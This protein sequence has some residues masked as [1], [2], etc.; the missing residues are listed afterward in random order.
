MPVGDISLSGAINQIKATIEGSPSKH[1]FFFMV[2]AGVSQ[3]VIPDAAA[4]I[5]DCRKRPRVASQSPPEGVNE[6]TWF[7]ENAFTREERTVY[8]SDQ[9]WMRSSSTDMTNRS[10]VVG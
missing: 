10:K 3:P 6:Y 2:G 1:P 9:R 8:F 4:I 7:V 5:R